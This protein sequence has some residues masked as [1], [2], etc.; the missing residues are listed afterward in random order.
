M[1]NERCQNALSYN[2]LCSEHEAEYEAY[3][4]EKYEEELFL[5]LY[6]SELERVYLRMEEDTAEQ[7]AMYLIEKGA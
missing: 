6:E 7:H 1:C 4:L 5:D 3:L 2:D